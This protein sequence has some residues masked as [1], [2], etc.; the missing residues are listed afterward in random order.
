MCVATTVCHEPRNKHSTW[1]TAK[2]SIH[3]DIGSKQQHSRVMAT[4]GLDIITVAT[5]FSQKQLPAGT[6]NC[7]HSPELDGLVFRRLEFH[8]NQ[9]DLETKTAEGTN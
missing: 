1:F 8:L 2:C 7:Q 5:T 9:R 4:W 6:Q 3:E